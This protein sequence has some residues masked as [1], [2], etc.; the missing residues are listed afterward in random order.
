MDFT[1][2]TVPVT[3]L[4]GVVAVLWVAF[5]QYQGLIGAIEELTTKHDRFEYEVKLVIVESQMAELEGVE[6]TEEQNR[7]Y[8][9]YKKQYHRYMEER[10]KLL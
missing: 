6:R 9:A 5:Q 2:L 10:E 7:L 3:T 8:E 1:K 4:V